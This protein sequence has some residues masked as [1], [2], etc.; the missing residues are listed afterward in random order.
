MTGTGHGGLDSIQ[1]AVVRARALVADLD[2][3][4]NLTDRQQVA[5]GA[6]HELDTALRQIRALAAQLADAA[7]GNRPG[8]VRADGPATS[9]ATAR[10]ITM[11][12]GS[13]RRRILDELVAAPHGLCDLELQTRLNLNPSTQRPRRG[14]LA[15][16]GLIRPRAGV[17]GK[18]GHRT[19]NGTAWTVW[20]P[21]PAGYLAVGAD[22]PPDTGGTLF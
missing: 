2:R 18:P 1:A 22:P 11:R 19:I 5:A 14:E 20:E 12:T 21:T 17:D 10:A 9:R 4:D 6:R 8:K 16:H 7:G 13:V 15:D 3:V